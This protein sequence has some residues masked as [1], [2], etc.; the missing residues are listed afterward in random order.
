[1]TRGAA[2]ALACFFADIL[3]AH[4]QGGPPMITDDPGTPGD[5][6]WEINAAYQEDRTALVRQRSLPHIDLNYGLGDHIQLKYETGYL[7]V[8]GV[9]G[10][11]SVGSVS[12]SGSG[13][14]R[15]DLDDSLLGVKWRFL[16]QDK[17][18]FDVSMYPQLDLVNSNRSVRRGVA[19]SG[20]NLLLPIEV[21]HA[22]GSFTLVSEVGYQYS[23]EIPNEW[24][25]G[26][27]G[28]FEVTKQL[29]LMA[30]IHSAS[31]HFLTGGDLVVNVG[32]RQE[33]VGHLK[34]IAAAGT[35]LRNGTDTTR[36]VGYL[37]FQFSTGE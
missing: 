20:P 1:M 21:A 35:G 3:A 8:S 19:E 16:D 29:E 6:Q 24:V 7:V 9:G 37:G 4:A 5:G 10:I 26:V 17:A 2:L 22:F 25:A 11:D 23:S 14:T 31:E 18:K 15:R 34:L 32:L 13:G 30:E 28:A 36:F 12:G 33:I 27:L